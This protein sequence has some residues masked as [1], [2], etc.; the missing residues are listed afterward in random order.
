MSLDTDEASCLCLKTQTKHRVQTK[1][2]SSCLTSCSDTDVSSC[3]NI[4]SVPTDKRCSIMS[5]QPPPLRCE[6]RVCPL[7]LPAH[8]QR[9]F[10]K[11]VYKHSNHGPLPDTIP[12]TQDSDSRSCGAR[13]RT[14]LEKAKKGKKDLREG[15]VGTGLAA[16]NHLATVCLVAAHG[17]GLANMLVVATTEGVLYR[18][19]THTTHNGPLVPLGLYSTAHT[20]PKLQSAPKQTGSTE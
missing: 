2:M 18:V 3:V 12:K 14:Y 9:L 5:S 15:E 7:P 13:T 11:L 16:G 4:T 1:E 17:G 8:L 6:F 20:R 10:T 19:H